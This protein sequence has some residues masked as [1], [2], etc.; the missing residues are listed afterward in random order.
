[1]HHTSLDLSP[2]TTLAFE[3]YA[4]NFYKNKHKLRNFSENEGKE[5]RR[6]KINL[7]KQLQNILDSL[8]RK[9]YT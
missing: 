9:I 7:R 2:A 4:S 8:S 1:M 5:T 3:S 6:R